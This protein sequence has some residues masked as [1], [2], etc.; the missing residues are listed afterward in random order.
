MPSS[1]AH[2][3]KSLRILCVDDERAI[4]DIIA[5]RLRYAGHEVD[6]AEDGLAALQKVAESS[7]TYDVVITD[8]LMP[9]LT[10]VGLAERLRATGYGGAIVFFSSTLDETSAE[11]LAPLN[12][13]AAIEKGGP[14]DEL[15]SALEKVSRAAE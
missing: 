7:A 10:G 4:R 8:N 14:I 1:P 2:P 15:M 11:R 6:V 12:I 5:L 9:R 13:T 3:H